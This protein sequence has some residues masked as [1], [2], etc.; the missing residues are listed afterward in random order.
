MLRE[1]RDVNVPFYLHWFHWMEQTAFSVWLR[2]SPSALAFPNVLFL[3]TFGMSLVAGINA[4]IDLGIL[5][6]APGMRIAPMERF[7]PL[8]WAA[9][10]VA[11][12]TGTMLLMAYPA[13]AFTNPVWYIKFAFIGAALVVMRLIKHQV[14]R[15]D[16]DVTP[17]SAESKRLAAVSLFLWAGAITS[18]KLLAHTYTRLYAY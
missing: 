17:I 6:F 12:V 10:W 5:G 13:K 4:A 8:M 9:F 7:F 1:P 14:F 11:A 2:E 3:H 15:V 16:L 18:G